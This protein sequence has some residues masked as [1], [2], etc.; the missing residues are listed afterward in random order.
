MHELELYLA[1]NACEGVTPGLYHYDALN[2]R[3]GRI[4]GLTA[5]VEPLLRQ[6]SWGT[7][8]PRERLQVLVILAARFQRVAWKYTAIAYALML[9]PAYAYLRQAE[10]PPSDQAQRIADLF[11]EAAWQSVR[12]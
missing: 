9:G 6:A 7:G 5:E 8:I 12:A 3:L 11:A 2:H 1:I 10:T 4:S